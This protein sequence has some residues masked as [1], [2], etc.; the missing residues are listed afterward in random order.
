MSAALPIETVSN[1]AENDQPLSP[2]VFWARLSEQAALAVTGGTGVVLV[3]TGSKTEWRCVG[4]WQDAAGKVKVAAALRQP[5]WAEQAQAAN[6]RFCDAMSENASVLVFG[7]MHQMPNKAGA[8]V[9]LA[10]AANVPAAK[11][12]P[13]LDRLAV[14]AA[15]APIYQLEFVLRQARQDVARFATIL[16]L[17]AVLKG[18]D[19]FMSAAMALTNELASRLH[20][21]RVSIG[22]L[23]K[24]Y[25]HVQAISHVEKFERKM[26]AVQLLEGAM[27]EALE[28]DCEIVWPAPDDLPAV[29]RD[30]Q[31]YVEAQSLGHIFSIPLRDADQKPVAV[32]TIERKA[33]AFEDETLEWMRVCADQT[34]SLLIPLEER[35]VWFGKRW[36]RG[37]RKKAGKLIG[38][39]HTGAKLLAIV[40]VA[41]L[42]FLLFGRWPHRIKADFSLRAE[43]AVILPAPFDGYLASVLTEK[44]DVVEAGTVLALLDIRELLIEKTAAAA[45]FDRYTREAEKAR[46]ERDLAGMRMAEAL[47]RQAAARLALVQHRLQ[48]AEIKSP[49]AGAVLEGDLWERVGAPLRQGDL[50][51]KVARLT[52]LT[53]DAEVN[54]SDIDFVRAGAPVRLVFASRPAHGYAATI[55]RIDPMAQSLDGNNVFLARCVIDDAIESWWRPGM[56]GVARIDAGHRTPIWLLTRRTLDY[57]RLR[58]GW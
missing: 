29:S 7:I 40:G 57:L 26:D 23:R 11:K 49:I 14:V 30:H 52:S 39:E 33:M 16:D 5:Q 56:S 48:Q 13:L 4:Q 19:R 28:Q 31:R 8:I 43:D 20:A 44:G 22:W 35:D 34:A 12:E 47:G 6:G 36:W 1:D 15:Q 25:I 10:A 46:A 2:A 3:Q 37:F 18:H 42:A 21:D 41:A 55:E 24:G 32:I 17:L 9:V 45:D 50:L 38:V 27:E 54:E 58:W 53:V 51:F